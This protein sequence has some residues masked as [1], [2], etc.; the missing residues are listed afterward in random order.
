ML[1]NNQRKLINKLNRK[2]FRKSE[3]LFIAEGEK[4]L[5]EAIQSEL[6]VENVFGSPEF[7]ENHPDIAGLA[8]FEEVSEEELRKVS[9]LSTPNKALGI[10]KIPEHSLSLLQLKK[11]LFLIAESINDPGNLGTMIRIADWFGIN[12]IICSLDTVDA[13]NPKV[14]QS[15]MGSL[16]RVKVHY[17]GLSEFLKECREEQIPVYATSLKGDNIYEYELKSR[18]GVVM[19]SESHGLS[20]ETESMADQLLRIPSFGK[21]ES[22]NVASATAII[23][24]EFRKNF[25]G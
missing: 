13:Y 3:N 4:V 20:K 2:K 16:F 25:P 9:S 24:S 5:V 1:S 18:G 15:A 7:I 8:F 6:T 12:N 17:T 22:L 10:I 11:E 23:C 21:A 19:G 14:V